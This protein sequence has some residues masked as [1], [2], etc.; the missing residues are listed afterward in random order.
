MVEKQQQL[1][2]SILKDP[3]VASLS[4]F[5]GIDQTSYHAPAKPGDPDTAISFPTNDGFTIKMDCTIE[6]E[7]LPQDQPQLRS[8]TT[9]APNGALVHIKWYGTDSFGP[10]YTTNLTVGS[11]AGKKIRPKTSAAAVP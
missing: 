3:A 10:K 5:V 8:Y 6:W 9:N 1:V 4:S 11:D 2:A 7:V